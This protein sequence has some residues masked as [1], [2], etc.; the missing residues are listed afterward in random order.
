MIDLKSIQEGQCLSQT[1][2]GML[3]RWSDPVRE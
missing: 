1:C 2:Q 3:N